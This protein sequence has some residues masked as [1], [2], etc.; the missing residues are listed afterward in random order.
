MNQHI[1]ADFI[2]IPSGLK[3]HN[4]RSCLDPFPSAILCTWQQHPKFFGSGVNTDLLLEEYSVHYPVAVFQMCIS[5]FSSFQQLTVIMFIIKCW[6]WQYSNHGSLVL[7]ATR[8][9]TEPQPLPTHVTVTESRNGH[10]I[11]LRSCLILA[12]M[13]AQSKVNFIPYI[14]VFIFLLLLV[15]KYLPTHLLAYLVSNWFTQWPDWAIL[16]FFGHKLYF[17]TSPDVL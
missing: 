14:C 5:L 1:F 3:H 15:K 2:E 8:L 16:R 13:A 10:S 17:E 7:E 9:A 4:V 11:G 6:Q 12:F